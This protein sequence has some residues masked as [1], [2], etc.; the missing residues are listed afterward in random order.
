MLTWL[1]LSDLHFRENTKWEKDPLLLE[2][3]EDIDER[4]GLDFGKPNLVCVT[5]DI[6]HSGKKAEYEMVRPFL[7]RIQHVC[8]V[9]ANQMFMVPGNHDV[10][11]TLL[12]W[13]V[14]CTI[15]ELRAQMKQD[16]IAEVFQSPSEQD[17]RTLLLKP[18]EAYNEFAPIGCQITPGQLYWT[19]R[20]SIPTLC[21][22]LRL[23]GLNS[24]W[25]ATGDSDHGGLL[26]GRH[27]VSEALAQVQRREELVLALVHHPF[28]W[29]ADWD[30]CGVEDL[31]M[32]R[33]DVILRGHLHRPSELVVPAG[34]LLIASGNACV[35]SQYP[36]RYSFGR[37]DLY[38]GEVQLFVRRW[39]SERGGM[40]T[41]DPVVGSDKSPG[42]VIQQLPDRLRARRTAPSSSPATAPADGS[43]PRSDDMASTDRGPRASAV[44][45]DQNASSPK[46]SAESKHSG[47]LPDSPVRPLTVVDQLVKEL[48]KGRVVV[49]AGAGLS[50]SAGLPLFSELVEPLR[51]EL[52]VKASHNPLDVAD[53]YRKAR[54]EL[55]LLKHV[56][57]ALRTPSNPDLAN[58]NRMLDLGCR[59]IVTTNY[60]D[61]FEETFRQRRERVNRIL[62][63]RHL[64]FVNETDERQL[65]KA[66][67]DLDTMELV[68][69]ENDYAQFFTKHS[70]FVLQ[71]SAL[72]MNR[73]ILFVGYSLS[74]PNIL[75]LLDGVR[76]TVEIGLSRSYMVT[77]GADMI[78]RDKWRKREIETIDLI[79]G[80]RPGVKL[81]YTAILGR[82]LEELVGRVRAARPAVTRA[83][84]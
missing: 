69:T 46:S 68:L 61:L 34:A 16:V 62:S 43:L 33:V 21:R 14:K 36:N 82:W 4:I 37:L 78:D 10:D 47:Q 7:E 8:G 22:P 38:T 74:D 32:S 53:A 57:E 77:F 39:F 24:A 64:A 6:A 15:R 40:W 55:A 18:F 17:T 67:G 80:Q 79:E 12:C 66:H 20:L 63:S 73:P 1:H 51:S 50:K 59:W 23:L 30:G 29:L 65:L 41:W 81:D 26:M 27:Q 72:V 3:V 60:D 71:L 31:L 58:H 56:R 13:G 70:A 45:E 35:D 9:E 48:V 84:P 75:T 5:G 2:L 25:A 19:V 11:R 76:K 44:T 49:F 83:V 42:R 28:S 54:G 52:G